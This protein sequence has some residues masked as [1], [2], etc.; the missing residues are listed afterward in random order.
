MN[1]SRN[2]LQYYLLILFIFG[3]FFLY[4]K[5][6]VGNDYTMSDWLINYS[7]GFTK[8]GLIGQLSIYLSYFLNLNLRDSILVF[9]IVIFT[10]FFGGLFFFLKDIKINKLI[11]LSIF[12]PIFILHPI[13]EIEVLARKELFIYCIFLLYFSDISSRNY[14]VYSFSIITRRT[15]RGAKFI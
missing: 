9:Q 6:E 13:Y 2:Y 15:F 7:G 4:Q 3:V 11:L 5:H 10:I 14:S 12:T 1:S 8:R